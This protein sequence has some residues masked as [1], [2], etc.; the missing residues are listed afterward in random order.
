MFSNRFRPQSPLSIVR[1]EESEKVLAKLRARRLDPANFSASVYPID[2]SYW[3]SLNEAFGASLGG[4]DILT[5]R[6]GTQSY[7]DAIAEQVGEVEDA[8]PV[9]DLRASIKKE[10]VGAGYEVEIHLKREEA[11]NATAYNALWQK[12]RMLT[13][14]ESGEKAPVL[15]GDI[16]IAPGYGKAKPLD[17]T[18]TVNFTYPFADALKEKSFKRRDSTA[19]RVRLPEGE[20]HVVLRS[21]DQG[22]LADCVN[23]LLSPEKQLTTQ[24]AAPSS[25]LGR[26]K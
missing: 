22:L 14:T 18:P 25:G 8:I 11:S 19:Q 15:A 23:N 16:R 1:G 26:E 4:K 3:N 12:V 9:G 7:G 5:V 21:R 2:T 24:P 10:H 20:I 17:M 13:Q 6:N